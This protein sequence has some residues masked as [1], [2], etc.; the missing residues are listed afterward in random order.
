MVD[1][2]RLGKFE[3][4]VSFVDLLEICLKETTSNTAAE[5]GQWFAG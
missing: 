1:S 4:G 3:E 2:A 5:H